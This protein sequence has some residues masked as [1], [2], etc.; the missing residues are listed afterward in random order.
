MR[1]LI[2]SWRL[3]GTLLAGVVTTAIPTIA[4]DIDLAQNLLLWPAS[5]FSLTCGCTLLVSGSVADVVGSS[6]M[7]LIGS[8]LQSA[9]T[10]ACGLSTS[11][12][13]LILFRGLAG[14]ATSMCLPS[15]VSIITSTFVPGKRRN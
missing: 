3:L 8:A 11:G 14:I 12:S 10:L 15:A 5:I 7:Y 4:R 1:S 6:N 13:Q 9:F 2:A